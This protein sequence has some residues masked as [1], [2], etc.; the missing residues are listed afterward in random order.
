MSEILL[1]SQPE[2]IDMTTDELSKVRIGWKEFEV[3]GWKMSHLL[4]LSVDIIVAQVCPFGPGV[5]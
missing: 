1:L 5:A 2:Q 4:S 3:D